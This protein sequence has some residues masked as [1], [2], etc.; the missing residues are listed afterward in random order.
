MDVQWIIR[1][2]YE[3]LSFYYISGIVSTS[4]GKNSWFWGLDHTILQTH[5]FLKSWFYKLLN[6]IPSV[7]NFLLW[8]LLSYV[9]IYMTWS[10]KTWGFWTPF[11][12][13]DH[14]LVF[15][16]FWILYV[17]LIKRKYWNKKHMTR[18]IFMGSTLHPM[19]VSMKKKQ[20]HSNW[21]RFKW[22]GSFLFSSIKTNIYLSNYDLNFFEA[23]LGHSNKN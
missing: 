1:S 2:Q 10:T 13:F 9:D 19:K 5:T 7:F 21:N 11:Y 16:S 14:F 17:F 20:P 3:T 6:D 23:P 8:V 15:G 22:L 4:Q 12:Y 18:I